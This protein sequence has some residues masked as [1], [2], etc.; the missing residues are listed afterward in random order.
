MWITADLM[1]TAL[2][3][4]FVCLY[5]TKPFTATIVSTALFIDFLRPP[6]SPEQMLRCVV[7]HGKGPVR[8][9]VR[10]MD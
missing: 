3:G 10:L 2:Q 4:L 6:I 9:P 7:R 8:Y 5:A 1:N